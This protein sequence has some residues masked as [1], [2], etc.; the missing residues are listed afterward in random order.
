MTEHSPTPW[1]RE[2]N[3]I[4]CAPRKDVDGY[5][6]WNGCVI[7]EIFTWM[8]AEEAAAN[9]A[10]FLAAPSLAEFVRVVAAMDSEH[11]DSV[12][13]EFLL[14][15]IDRARVLVAAMEAKP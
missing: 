3:D 2:G 4:I 11:K 10:L 13:K 8:G 12:A 5:T 9:A 6:T 7:A 15:M 1:R 14:A